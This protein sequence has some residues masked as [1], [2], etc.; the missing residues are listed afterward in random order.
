MPTLQISRLDP[1]AK[2]P[3]RKPNAEAFDIFAL[4]GGV[5]VPGEQMTFRTGIACRVPQGFAGIILPKARLALQHS[6][7]MSLGAGIIDGSF[8]NELLIQVRNLGE[9]HFVVEPCDAIA[10][11]LLVEQPIVDLEEV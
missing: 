7:Q 4:N 2:L 10:Q 8:C 6:V 1:R 3:Q 5:L 9:R 11:L